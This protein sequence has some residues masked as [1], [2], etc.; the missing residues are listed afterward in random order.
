MGLVIA[1]RRPGVVEVEIPVIG[2][3][4]A[5][6]GFSIAQISDIH[7]G[8]TIKRGFVEGIVHRVNGLNPD[9]IAVTGD[10]VDGSVQELSHHTAPL[11]GLSARHGAYFVTGNHEYYSGSAHGPRSC[12][13]LACKC[14]KTSMSCWRTT[15]SRSSSLE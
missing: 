11:A 1:R 13:G 12:G 6:R 9:L 5:L 2:L 4:E 14:S 15:A 10:L 3:P 8:P 7:V